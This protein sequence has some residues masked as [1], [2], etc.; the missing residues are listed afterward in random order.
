MSAL[1][2][3]NITKPA[4]ASIKWLRRV[5]GWDQL[6]M[7]LQHCLHI[8]QAPSNVVGPLFAWQ[9]FCSRPPTRLIQK[10]GQR[11]CTVAAHNLR[12]I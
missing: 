11:A 6:H 7:L 10:D 5:Q 4:T 12:L 3:A 9:I 1:S 2:L 8:L